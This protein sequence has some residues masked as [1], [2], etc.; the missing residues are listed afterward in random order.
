[1]TRAEFEGIVADVTHQHLAA[2]RIEGEQIYR[3]PTCGWEVKDEF[4]ATYGYNETVALTTGKWT[5]W[6]DPTSAWLLGGFVDGPVPCCTRDAAFNDTIVEL[7][8]V[9]DDDGDCDEE[10]GDRSSRGAFWVA[11]ERDAAVSAR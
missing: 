9:F 1:M 7:W 5:C 6:H 8:R 4:G 10:A 2:M 11:K 3:C